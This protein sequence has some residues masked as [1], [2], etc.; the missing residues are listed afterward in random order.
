MTDKWQR[1]AGHRQKPDNT[2]NVD[3]CLQA[4]ECG[5]TCRNQLGEHVIRFDRNLQPGKAEHQKTTYDERA[6]EKPRLR[7]S[8][9]TL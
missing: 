6:T 2:T 9:S 8:E 4:E 1:D 7:T 5:Y 3:D